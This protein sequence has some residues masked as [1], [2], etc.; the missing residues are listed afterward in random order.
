VPHLWSFP[1]IY[2]SKSTFYPC[3]WVY[4]ALDHVYVLSPA[5]EHDTQEEA[6][7]L[8]PDKTVLRVRVHVRPLCRFVWKSGHRALRHQRLGRPAR[9][10][11]R[12]H[13]ADEITYVMAT[14]LLRSAFTRGE[15]RNSCRKYSKIMMVVDIKDKFRV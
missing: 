2:F 9:Y 1:H 11:Y 8:S 5:D 3:K 6:T 4:A 7:V 13:L 14:G 12:A 15:R 10:R